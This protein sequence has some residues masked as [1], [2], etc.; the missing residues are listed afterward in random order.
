MFLSYALVLSHPPT[1][2]GFGTGT[3]RLTLEAFLGPLSLPLTSKASLRLR[4]VLMVCGFAY[5]PTP[6]IQCHSHRTQ[7][8]RVSVP[9]SERLVVQEY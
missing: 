7:E 3:F 1:C 8:A 6:R 5:I 2:V 9:S 4:R